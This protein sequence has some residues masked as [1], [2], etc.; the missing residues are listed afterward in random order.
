V[1]LAPK[2]LL[3][4]EQRANLLTYSEQFDNAAWTKQNATITANFAV[5][6]SGEMTADKITPD[7][8]TTF[9][10]TLAA[11]L[12]AGTFTF[13]IFAKSSGYN[14]WLQLHSTNGSTAY[15]DLT[16][17]TATNTATFPATFGTGATQI[18]K[19]IT[20]VGNGW[21]RCILTAT[22]PALGNVIMGV[23][24]DSSTASF[25]GDGTSG[26][27]VWGAQLE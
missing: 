14:L 12:P 18:S 9:H 5:S 21:Y 1:T 15:F 26:V 20:P 10:T 8:T 17:V 19:T 27:F 23:S 11:G 16:N 6:P 2:G 13:S 3:I 24:P 22:V 25:A 4:E 7:T